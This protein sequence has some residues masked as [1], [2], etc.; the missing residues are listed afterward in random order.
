MS[1]SKPKLRKQSRVEGPGG[2]HF[3]AREQFSNGLLP[4]KREI[5]ERMIFHLLPKSMSRDEAADTV[6]DELMQHWVYCNVYTKQRKNVSKAI[7]SLYDEFQVKKQTGKHR[8]T[9]KWFEETWNPYLL[10][11]NNGFDIRAQTLEARKKQ[12]E[13]FGVKETETEEK[14][15]KDQIEGERKMF[16]EAFVD[17]KWQSLHD[18][19][20]KE[21]EGMERLK[22]KQVLEVESIRGLTLTEEIEEEIGGAVEETRDDNDNFEAEEQ[23]SKRRRLVKEVDPCKST[24]LPE[25]WRHVRHSIG[26]VDITFPFLLVVQV[27]FLFRCVLLSTRPLIV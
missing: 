25:D 12:E 11:L 9:P 16:C 19:R 23:S 20:Q 15:W 4:S 18:R 6:A 3:Y 22:E 5:I 13:L 2:E 24:S 7:K 26:K 17:R 21:K 10:S 1:L 8:Q 27:C 14:F